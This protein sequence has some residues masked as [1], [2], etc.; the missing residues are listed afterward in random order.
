MIV[1]GVAEIDVEI[2][3][4][5]LP[6]S[7]RDSK[8]EGYAFFSEGDVVNPVC[9]S[10]EIRDRSMGLKYMYTARSPSRLQLWC[11]VT[12]SPPIPPWPPRQAAFASRAVDASTKCSIIFPS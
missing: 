4:G 2:V 12:I 11:D 5:V 6:K 10:Y 1:P 3:E 8:V 7:L 9:I